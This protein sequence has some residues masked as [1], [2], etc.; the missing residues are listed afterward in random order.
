MT[1]FFIADL[2]LSPE[3]PEVTEAFLAFLQQRVEG[4]EA[5]YIL[6]DLFEAWIGDDDPSPLAR[7]VLGALRGLTRGGTRLYFQHGNRDFLVGKRFA[8][9]TGAALLTDEALVELDGRRVLVM[10]G[11][12]LCLDD[13]AYQRFRRKVRFPPVKWLLAHLPLKKRLQI[14]ARWRAGS[15]AANRNKPDSIMDVTPAEVERL[16]EHY[17]VD[18]LI[19][20]HTHRPATHE[21]QVAGRAGQRWVVGDWDQKAWAIEAREGEL[22]L[23]SWPIS[24]CV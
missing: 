15:K 18:T 3:R 5:L 16:M 14:A 10:H 11:D 12:S 13:E 1:T 21:V 20:G 8:A 6:G 24:A 19:H 4:A 9:A 22:E 7:Q 17:Q 2:H 23:Q